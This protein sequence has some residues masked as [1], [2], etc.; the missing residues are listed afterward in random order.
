MSSGFSRTK[1]G[2]NTKPKKGLASF[3]KKNRP[4][5]LNTDE[6]NWSTD[7][8]SFCLANFHCVFSQ[9]QIINGNF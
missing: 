9:A 4:T 7:R 5:D 2:D 6:L 8:G 1:Q 3:V